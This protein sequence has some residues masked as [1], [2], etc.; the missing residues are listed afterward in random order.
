MLALV[1]IGMLSES[2]PRKFEAK[3][4]F[5]RLISGSSAAVSDD[6]LE[7]LV[8]TGLI[9]S[10]VRV[11]MM[12]AIALEASRDAYMSETCRLKSGESDRVG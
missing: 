8:P 6:D 1:S 10:V 2:I 5:V 3:W 9:D 11:S 4:Y 12:E 7:I